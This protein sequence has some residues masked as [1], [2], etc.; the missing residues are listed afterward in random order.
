MSNSA[1]NATKHGCCAVD[2]RLIPGESEKEYRNLERIWFEAYTPKSDHQR[3][4]VT[5]LVN[6]DWLLQRTTRAYLDIETRLYAKS[7]NPLDWTEE[8]Q[9]T[10]GRF[11]RYKT[12]HTNNV[13]KCRKA[14]EDFRK[15]RMAENAVAEKSALAQERLKAT[16]KRSG[17]P[18][19]KQH[20][21]DMRKQAIALG[22]VNASDPDP[23]AE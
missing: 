17:P 4:L 1:L 8:E 23:F 3:H 5:E 15:A 9:R 21:R 14:I 10:L 11:Q 20:L 18:D 13:I 7:T 6:A 19:W 2:A 16:Q 12:A 22:Y